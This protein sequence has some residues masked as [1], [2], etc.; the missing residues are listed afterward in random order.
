MRRILLAFLL[1]TPVTVFAACPDPIP[2]DTICL[3]WQAPTQNVDGTPLTDLAGFEVFWGL[4]S[5]DFDQ[6][7]KIDIPDATQTEFTTPATPISIPTP[8]PEGGDVPVFFVMTAY[9]DDGNVSA[10]SNEVG[11]IVTFLDTNPPGAPQ[12]LNVII[13]VTT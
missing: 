10:F 4:A 8:G 6:S 13:N 5:G 12:L 1:L 2:V 9:D 3:E 7:R 11:K